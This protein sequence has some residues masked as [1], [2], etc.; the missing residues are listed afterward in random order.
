MSGRINF[1]YAIVPY[2]KKN[3]VFTKTIVERKI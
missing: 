1:I 3:Y 2:K